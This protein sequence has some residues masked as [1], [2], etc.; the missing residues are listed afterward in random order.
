MESVP[1]AA[2]GNGVLSFY[3]FLHNSWLLGI[4][5][6]LGSCGCWLLHKVTLR[7]DQSSPSMYVHVRH[8]NSPYTKEHRGPS[9]YISQNVFT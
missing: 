9:N 2:P 4:S 6:V 7:I 1:A 3:N 8:V 5:A